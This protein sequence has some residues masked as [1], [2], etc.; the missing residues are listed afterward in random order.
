MRGSSHEKSL[1]GLSTDVSGL[2]AGVGIGVTSDVPGGVGEQ[3]VSDVGLWGVSSLVIDDVEVFSSGSAAFS[4]L[5][6]STP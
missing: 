5:P 1:G 4:V 3:L 6:F 2:V